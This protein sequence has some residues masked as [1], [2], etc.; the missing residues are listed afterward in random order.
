MLAG[1]VRTLRWTQEFP[2]STFLSF[3]VRALFPL[4]FA[5]GALSL[6]EPDAPPRFAVGDATYEWVRG[7]AQL[8]EGMALGNTHGC[9]VVD[10]EDRVYLNTDTEN[11]V[12]VF[13][14]DGKFLQAWGKELAGGLHGMAL[15][16]RDGRQHLLLAHIGRHQV[17][18]STLEG[19]IVWTLDYPKEAGI[20]EKAEQYLP[21]SVAPIPDSAGGGFLVADGYGA[22]WIHRYDR[23]R[24]YVKSFGGPGSE[25]GKLRCPHGIWVETR[26][27]VPVVLVAD[28][29]N[30]R[31]QVFDLDGGVQK[32]IKDA[33]HELLRRPCHLHPFQDRFAVADLAGRVT[34]LGRDLAL[35][36]HL[37]DN[38]DPSKRA[39]NGVPPS[40]W[41]DGEF[42]SPH[43][44]NFDSRGDLYVVDWLASG[45]VNKL[46]RVE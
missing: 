40:E 33:E 7:W 27:D 16:E 4:A 6:Q 10:S 31:L 19:E 29:E 14:R 46:A 21:T 22:S 17:L 23:E 24:R 30:G 28:R 25:L 11:A 42:V 15:V 5:C 2:M 37:G 13:D 8:P 44:A 20:Y 34:L 45:R 36:G 38:P 12:V 43:C 1:S 39:Q 32:E 26:G 18:E 41:K 9:I 35:I 3:G